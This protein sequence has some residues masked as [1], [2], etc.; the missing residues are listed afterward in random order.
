MNMDGTSLRCDVTL[1]RK[2]SSGN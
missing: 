1:T 2:I